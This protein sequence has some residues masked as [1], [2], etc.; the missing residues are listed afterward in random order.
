VR[1]TDG[2]NKKGEQ[3]MTAQTNIH[4]KKSRMMTYVTMG[5]GMLALPLAM[6]AEAHADGLKISLNLG[7]GYPMYYHPPVQ[8]IVYRP[9][10]Q[11]VVYRP[12]YRPVYREKVVYRDWRGNRGH[13]HQK[14]AHRGHGKD[15]GHRVAWR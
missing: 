13:G 12:V 11:R 6:P 9:A 2:L 5:A 1:F 7:G 4:K 10:P 8:K 15:R 14:H 3:T